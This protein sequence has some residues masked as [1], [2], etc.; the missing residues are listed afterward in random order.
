MADTKPKFFEA[1]GRAGF[2][3]T[4]LSD[5]L[6]RPVRPIF[7]IFFFSFVFICL[8]IT[9]FVKEFRGT[10]FGIFAIQKKRSVT[11]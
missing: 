7:A 8:C 4:R 1:L 6:M 5:G 9:I 11:K 3:Y 10:T 2:K